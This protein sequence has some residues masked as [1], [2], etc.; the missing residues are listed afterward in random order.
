MVRFGAKKVEAIPPFLFSIL[1]RLFLFFPGFSAVP[2]LNYGKTPVFLRFL[3]KPNS[4]K[5]LSLAPAESPLLV[6]RS[7][8]VR[9]ERPYAVCCHILFKISPNLIEL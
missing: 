3:S 9:P 2:A 4:N 8:S 7:K 1:S 6:E 5:V